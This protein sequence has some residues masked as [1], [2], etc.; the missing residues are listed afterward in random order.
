M[1]KSCIK[2]IFGHTDVSRALIETQSEQ[3][4]ALAQG[5]KSVAAY[6]YCYISLEVTA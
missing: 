3:K 1:R 5:E 6:G 4:S 2:T